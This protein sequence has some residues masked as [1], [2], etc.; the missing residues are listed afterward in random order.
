MTAVME[1][2]TFHRWVDRLSSAQLDRLRVM[3]SRDGE[4]PS[5]EDE[6]MASTDEAVETWLRET[7]LPVHQRVAAGGG[8]RVTL[9]ESRA[10][11]SARLAAVA[12]S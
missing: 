12:A 2:P 9:D 8:R 5:I 7:V 6:A 3:V 11:I 1:A 10:R 4:L